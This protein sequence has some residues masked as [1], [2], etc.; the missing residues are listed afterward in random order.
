MARVCP[1][2]SNVATELVSLC[3]VVLTGKGKGTTSSSSL[4]LSETSY[5]SECV[6]CSQ[7]ILEGKINHWR[8]LTTTRKIT[9]CKSIMP[10]PHYLHMFVWYATELRDIENFSLRLSAH[11]CLFCTGNTGN[12]L[13]KKVLSTLHNLDDGNIWEN[14]DRI[15]SSVCTEGMVQSEEKLWMMSCP[16]CSMPPAVARAEQ[17]SRNFSSLSFTNFENRSEPVSVEE[18]NFL[19]SSWRNFLASLFNLG[20]VTVCPNQSCASCSILQLKPESYTPPWKNKPQ[21]KHCCQ[22]ESCHYVMSW[23]N[24]HHLQTQRHKIS[25]NPLTILWLHKT[26]CI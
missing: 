12:S 15:S 7:V 19:C 13:P 17:C 4:S 6:T 26:V 24:T 22:S 20:L 10:K 11:I 16:P 5:N 9:T 18:V 1:R 3:A 14:G 8:G 23:K 21:S 25:I 2:F